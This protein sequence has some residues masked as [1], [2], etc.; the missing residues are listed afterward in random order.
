MI[1]QQLE[2]GGGGGASAKTASNKKVGV[3]KKKKSESK[4]RMTTHF[5]RYAAYLLSILNDIDSFSSALE[6]LVF[7]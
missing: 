2:N 7:K 5:F 1:Q 3:Y 6:R 4:V